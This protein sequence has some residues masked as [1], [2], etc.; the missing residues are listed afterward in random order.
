MSKQDELRTIRRTI[1]GDRCITYHHRS[2][3]AE[4]DG[5][6]LFDLVAHVQSAEDDLIEAEERDERR[7]I[8]ARAAKVFRVY[9]KKVYSVEERKILIALMRD[10]KKKIK[11]IREENGIKDRKITIRIFEKWERTRGKLKRAFRLVGFD[12][13]RGKI[14]AFARIELLGFYRY[15]QKTN[16]EEYSRMY[17]EYWAAHRDEINRK[18]RERR[19]ENREEY[20]RRNRQWRAAHR[21]E[22]NRTQRDRRA[23]KRESKRKRRPRKRRPSKRSSRR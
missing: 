16:S 11:A 10:P 17:R 14:A 2:G 18:Q 12:F 5:E 19:A 21:E 23:A 20:N 3:D 1:S 4:E 15:Y 8:R 7:E 9:L 6:M 13:M 22:N